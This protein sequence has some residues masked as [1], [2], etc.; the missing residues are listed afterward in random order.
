MQL[1]DARARPG[2]DDPKATPPSSKLEDWAQGALTVSQLASEFG[3][4]KG[5]AYELMNGGRLVW[6]RLDGR[7]RIARRSVMALLAS[8]TDRDSASRTEP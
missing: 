1:R 6:G 8:P 5:K 3:I 2:L 4:A 7:R